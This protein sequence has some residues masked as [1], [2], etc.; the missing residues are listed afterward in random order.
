MVIVQSVEGLMANFLTERK[1]EGL[2]DVCCK[3]NI[4]DLELFFL[5]KNLKAK[6]CVFSCFRMK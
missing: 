2:I 3:C 1:V 5:L 6:M 4:L